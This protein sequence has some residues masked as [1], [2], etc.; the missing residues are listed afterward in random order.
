MPKQWLAKQQTR[1]G[2]LARALAATAATSFAGRPVSAATAKAPLPSF[3]LGFL[4]G[5]VPLMRRETWTADAPRTWLLREGGV[6]DRI[7]IHHQGGRPSVT[8]VQNS[9]MAEIDAI[10]GGHRRLRYGDIAYHF[11]VDYAGRVWEGRSLA[12][13]G[14]HVSAQNARNLGILFLGNF[15][16]QT[17]SGESIASVTKLVELLRERFGVKGHRLYG[18][19]DLGSS[20]CPGKHLYPHVVALRDGVEEPNRTST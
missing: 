11:V 7:T 1:R 5:R 15:E 4:E 19:R 20:V 10:Y 17:P 14:A 9:V 3:D 8:R 13:E 6:Y 2:F 16:Q 18:H 12:Y